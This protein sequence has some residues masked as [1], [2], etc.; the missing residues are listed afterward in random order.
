M[1]GICSALINKKKLKYERTRRMQTGGGILCIGNE[2]GGW[3]GDKD[4]RE[5]GCLDGWPALVGP[6]LRQTRS[7]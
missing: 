5:S 2:T 4:P 6:K 7:K 3:Q 1:E